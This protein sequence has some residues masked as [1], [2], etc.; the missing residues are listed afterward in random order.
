MVTQVEVSLIMFL[1]DINYEVMVVIKGE[2]TMTVNII[3]TELRSLSLYVKSVGS[4]DTPRIS[5]SRS[6]DIQLARS[7]R[8][9]LVM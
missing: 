3:Q 7:Q 4:D 8:G 6:K 5:A 1:L 2:V 9:K